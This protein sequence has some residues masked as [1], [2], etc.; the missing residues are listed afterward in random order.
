M[1]EAAVLPATPH[2]TNRCRGH[3]PPLLL[4]NRA[5]E[6]AALPKRRWP[7]F[8]RA[9]FHPNHRLREEKE[10]EGRPPIRHRPARPSGRLHQ[11]RPFRSA[12]VVVGPPTIRRGP[13]NCR[14]H[15]RRERPF[16]PSA[17]AEA[18]QHRSGNW[19]ANLLLRVR[20]SQHPPESEAAAVPLVGRCRQA[21]PQR[22]RPGSPN[23]E[24]MAEAAQPQPPFHLD[25]L[26]PRPATHGVDT[27]ATAAKVQPQ[28]SGLDPLLQLYAPRSSW[29]RPVVALLQ[30][31]PVQLCHVASS[32][33]SFQHSAAELLQPMVLPAEGVASVQS[34]K[35][36]KWATSGWLLP[37]RA[38]WLRRTPDRAA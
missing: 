14:G 33:R 3:L 6:V 27:P 9:L 25:S 4:L 32:R 8:P 16:F 19:T 30:P 10:A 2:R 28:Q 7:L 20:S 21:S 35:G 11:D 22:Q 36:A 24:S 31:P 1:T 12:K 18:E 38:T 29:Q 17:K 13:A 5:K 26:G 37:D 15:Y 34:P 23:D